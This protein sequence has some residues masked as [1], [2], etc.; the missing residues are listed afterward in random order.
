MRADLLIAK[1][2]N[3]EYLV[4]QGN[5][6]VFATKNL[7]EARVRLNQITSGERMIVEFIN[8]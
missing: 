5:S 3:V 2:N 1:E 7:E 8:G 6:V 4:V